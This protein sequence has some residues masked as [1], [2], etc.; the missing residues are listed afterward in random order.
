[1]V[2]ETGEVVEGGFESQTKQVLRN[3]EAILTAAGLTWCDVLKTT[4]F[5]TDLAQ[6]QVFNTLYSGKFV[7]DPPARAVVQVSSLPRD[8]QIEME[9]VALRQG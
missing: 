2:A 3:F 5:L 9:G 7:A 1:M 4:V 6:F 8:V